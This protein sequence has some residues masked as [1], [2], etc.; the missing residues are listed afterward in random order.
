MVFY[1]IDG[2]ISARFSKMTN[3]LPHAF[4]FFTFSNLE[5]AVPTMLARFRL[6]LTTDK[7]E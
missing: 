1:Y 5:E 6:G 2:R 4:E 3:D 7:K